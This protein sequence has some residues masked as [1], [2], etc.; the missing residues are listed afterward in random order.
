MEK[1]VKATV[2]TFDGEKQIEGRLTTDHSASSYGH[3]AF[4]D[5]DGEAWDSWQIAKIEETD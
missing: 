2:L 3:P 5:E 1:K 4:V